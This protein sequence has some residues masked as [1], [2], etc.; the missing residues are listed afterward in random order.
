MSNRPL[1][2]V[3]SAALILLSLGVTAQRFVPSPDKAVV[4][5]KL[6]N[7][8]PVTDEMLRKPAPENWISF[9]NGYSL[10]GYS[11][12]SQINVGNVGQLRLVGAQGVQAGVGEVCRAREHRKIRDRDDRPDPVNP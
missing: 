2:F 7:F 12:L 5:E 9:R 11:S 10:W 1:V 3:L 4:P 8:V 6:K